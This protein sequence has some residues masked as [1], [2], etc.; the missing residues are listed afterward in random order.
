MIKILVIEDNQDINQMLTDAL[1]NQGYDVY[2]SYNAVEGLKLFREQTFDCIITDLMLPIMSG[3]TLIKMVRKTSNVHIIVITAKTSLNDKLN[4]LRIGANDYIYKP[5]VPEE[6][7]YKLE[8]MFSKASKGKQISLNN[9]LFCFKEGLNQIMVNDNVVEL[10][11]IEYQM[12][13]YL[14][15]HLNTVV[16]RDQFIDALYAYGEEVFDRVIDVHIKNI[17]K[18]VKQ[19]TDVVFIKTVYGL[20]Y[21]LVGDLDE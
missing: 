20:G 9:G 4:N 15:Q 7:V 18:K 2:Q 10:T 16:S 17:R 21:R 8:N 3:E 5:F 11:T 14:F 13:K 6:V 12:V 19:F 1:I